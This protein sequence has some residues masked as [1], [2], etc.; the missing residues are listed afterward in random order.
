MTKCIPSSRFRMALAALALFGSLLP[1][2][3]AAMPDTP[4]PKHMERCAHLMA[5]WNRYHP[6]LSGHHDGQVAIARL[7]LYRCS[8]GR[9][10][11]ANQAFERILR[12]GLVPFPAGPATDIALTAEDNP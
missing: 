8:V 10:D 4:S 11:E 7:A 5:L 9:F 2:L 6:A 1:G 3:A 12:Q